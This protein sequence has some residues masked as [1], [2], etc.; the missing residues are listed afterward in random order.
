MA[1]LEQTGVSGQP[2]MIE[3]TSYATKKFMMEG[4]T[5]YTD[6]FSMDSESSMPNSSHQ[7]ADLF[8]STTQS[9][10][11]SSSEDAAVNET[12]ILCGKLYGRHEL[13]VHM[14]ISDI[15]LG[16]KVLIDFF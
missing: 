8:K 13:S 1:G 10:S 5:I 16:P 7:E 3:R 2:T 4:V 12:L 6:E 11:D 14:K 15:V 9:F